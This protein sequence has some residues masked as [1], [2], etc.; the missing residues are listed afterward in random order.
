MSKVMAIVA[1]LF[2]LCF[3]IGEEVSGFN[4]ICYYQC[5]DGVRAIN[6]SSVSLCPITLEE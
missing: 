6:I 3:L 5:I 2:T 1:L 4:K